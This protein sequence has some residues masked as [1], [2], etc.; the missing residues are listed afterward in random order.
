MFSSL[1]VLPF[2]GEWWSY[3]VENKSTGTYVL[4]SHFWKNTG[5]ATF[6]DVLFGASIFELCLLRIA[7][8]SDQRARCRTRVRCRTCRN[9]QKFWRSWGAINVGLFRRADPQISCVHWTFSWWRVRDLSM[10]IHQMTDRKWW[11]STFFQKYC[12]ILHAIYIY[13]Y[14]ICL[15]I[16]YDLYSMCMYMVPLGSWKRKYRRIS[17][18]PRHDNDQMGMAET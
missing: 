6:E 2:V 18:E 9:K 7:P 17:W 16:M 14:I 4:T 1:G 8:V 12:S 13:I 5:Y 11:A 10:E 3:I 15:Q